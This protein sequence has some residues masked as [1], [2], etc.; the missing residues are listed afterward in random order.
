LRDRRA[1]GRAIVDA[2][3]IQHAGAAQEPRVGANLRVLRPAP[4]DVGSGRGAA[5]RERPSKPAGTY[6]SNAIVTSRT[7]CLAWPA[8]ST[9]PLPV[10]TGGVESPSR[11]LRFDAPRALII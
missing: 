7:E 6:T 11:F 3:R 4:E 9:V 10:P 2:R 5:V 1:Y 8:R